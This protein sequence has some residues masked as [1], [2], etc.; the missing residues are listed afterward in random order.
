MA[1]F[2]ERHSYEH[3]TNYYRIKECVN[4]MYLDAMAALDRDVVGNIKRYKHHHTIEED[5]TLVARDDWLPRVNEEYAK[6][7]LAGPWLGL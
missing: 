5:A 7:C 6:Y 3:T 2:C 4:K 1:Y